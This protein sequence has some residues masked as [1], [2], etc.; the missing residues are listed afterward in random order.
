MIFIPTALDITG[1]Q[2]GLLTA[3]K[4]APNK[5]KKT[6]WIC[7][8][9]CEEQ[10][11]IEVQT[12]HLTSGAITSCGCIKENKLIDDGIERN[13]IC[14]VCGNKFITTSPSRI[15]CYDCSPKGMGRADAIRLKKQVIKHKLITYKGGK[16]G[17][18]GYDKCE[19]A[20]Q[21]HHRDPSQKEFTIA[22]VNVNNLFSM[23]TLLDEV[24]KCDL[25][26]ANCHA[27]EHYT[28]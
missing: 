9:N 4:R 19:G 20:L 24:D 23:Q 5:G 17:K 13:M 10:N 8:C 11:E 21:F 28:G 18:C 1:K 2:F 12:G 15:Y 7:K 25:L 22:E 27:E 26:C 6:Y 16:C 14:P 3:I